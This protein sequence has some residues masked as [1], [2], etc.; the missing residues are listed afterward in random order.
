MVPYLKGFHL[1]IETWRGGRGEDGWPSNDD[2][3]VVSSRTVSSL[4]ATRSGDHGVNLDEAATYAPNLKEDEDEAGMDHRLSRR[5]GEERV[6]AP[7]SGITTAAPRLRDD[8]RALLKLSDFELPPLRVV[9]PSMVVSV[10]YGFGD[11]SGKEFGGTISENYN[12]DRALSKIAEGKDGLRFRIGVWN[13]EERLESSNFKELC[14]LVEFTESEAER[15]RLRNCEYF[16]FTDNST[17]ESCFYRGTSSSKILHSL[18][19]RL[20]LLEMKY[21]MLIHLIHVSGTRMIDQGTDA[22]SRGSLMEGVLAGK[23][24][25]SFVDLSVTAV[26]RHPPVLDWVR[27][28]TGLETLEPLTP[29]EWFVEGHGIVGGKKDRRGVWMPDHCPEIVCFYGRRSQLWLMLHWKNC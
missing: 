20:R 24:M 26:D 21:G 15:G 2:A 19:L 6:Y 16:L 4:D 7:S 23:D 1:S 9:R 3:S 29:E 18:V 10:F 11:A 5:L 17:A 13:A 22:A 27:S 8:V 12:C 25:L 28:W 14:N